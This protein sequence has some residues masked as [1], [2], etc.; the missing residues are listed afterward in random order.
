MAT[1]IF[2]VALGCLATVLNAFLCALMFGYLR[3]QT[4]RCW[5]REQE[6]TQFGYLTERV[7]ELQEEY[8]KL[9]DALSEA[10]DLME[11]RSRLHAALEGLKKEL[12]QLDDKRNELDDVTRKLDNL[13]VDLA[14]ATQRKQDLDQALQTGAMRRGELELAHRELSRKLDGLSQEEEA[15]KARVKELEARIE[16]LEQQQQEIERR[17]E[18]LERQRD[19]LESV[20]QTLDQDR[21]RKVEEHNREIGQLIAR[22]DAL[23]DEIEEQGRLLE[24]LKAEHRRFAAAVTQLCAEQKERTGSLLELKSTQERMQAAVGQLEQQKPKLEA[25]V[26]SLGREKVELERHVRRL[27]SKTKKLDERLT[28]TAGARKTVEQEVSALCGERDGLKSL[29]P[30]WREEA[31]RRGHTTDEERTGD[32]WEPVFQ[33]RDYELAAG[34]DERE[35]LGKLRDH[36]ERNNLRFHPRV[37]YAF[38]TALKVNDISPLVVLAGISGTGKSELPRRYAE[39]MGMHF[40]NLAVQPR[41]DSPQDMFGFFNYLDGRYRATELGRALIQMDPYY[42]EKDWGQPKESKDNSLHNQMLLVLLDEMNLARIEYYF[43]EFLSRLEIRRGVALSDHRKRQKAE[44]PLEVGRSGQGGSVMHV[45]VGQ[46]VVFA[47]TMNEDETTQSLSDKVVDRANVLRFAPPTKLTVVP[48]QGDADD[49][50]QQR[51]TPRLEYAHWRDKWC[52]GVQQRSNWLE[53]ED[54]GHVQKRLHELNSIMRKIRRPFAYRVNLAIEAYVANY[55]RIDS[56]WVNYAIAD[57]IEQK[58]LP[59]FRGLDLL[60][61]KE[62]KAALSDLKKVVAELNDKPLLHAVETAQK[63]EQFVWQGVNRDDAAG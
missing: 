17:R 1:D 32:L 39:A 54:R 19:R 20:V 26:E 35:Q 7:A 28:E 52:H 2:Y 24:G 62:L 57:Q 12:Q 23:K 33:A 36:L 16:K 46:N 15:G 59:K 30:V 11:E 14:D 63:G 41:W 27:R 18:D 51:Q 22:R 58:L 5:Q 53:P 49:N 43:S 38:H 6:A 42:K 21:W 48:T 40:L 50:G 29:L 3:R 10:K 44:I 25:K 37:L 31:K 55:P 47:G 4:Q 8:D 9:R 34:I 61:H 45:F 13:H 56:D 60:E